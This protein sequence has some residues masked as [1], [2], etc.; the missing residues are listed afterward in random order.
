MRQVNALMTWIKQDPAPEVLMLGDD[1]GVGD[2][3]HTWQLRYWPFVEKDEFGTPMVHSVF[4]R[5]QE[6]ATHDV[7]AYVNSDIMLVGFGRALRAVAE[8]FP[9]EFLMVGRRWDV[10][11][12]VP[13]SFGGD[14]QKALVQL[15]RQTGAMH[16]AGAIDYF[17]FRKGFYRN[18]PSFVPGRSAWDNWLVGDALER[19]ASVVDAT[20]AVWAVHQ[21]VPG[22]VHEPVSEERMEQRRRNR[23]FY[24]EARA[25][26]GFTGTSKE[27][28]WIVTET[29]QVKEK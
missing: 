7:V 3:A 22:A 8:T 6:Q 5:G 14:W 20:A 24:D 29:G 27:A 12:D 15:A 10:Q 26:H 28:R 1:P 21:D 18:V 19:G 11:V 2:M 17:A 13:L 4:E 16:S 23:A 25:R 9:G